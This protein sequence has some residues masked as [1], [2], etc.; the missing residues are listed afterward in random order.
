MF[1]VFKSSLVLKDNID[2]IWTY[3]EWDNKRKYLTTKGMA[4]YE[5][6]IRQDYENCIISTRSNNEQ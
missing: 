4:S 3:M 2:Y 6:V 5:L 1:I